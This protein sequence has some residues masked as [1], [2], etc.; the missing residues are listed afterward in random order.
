M[1]TVSFYNRETGEITGTI[2]VS[3]SVDLTTQLQGQDWIEGNWPGNRYQVL[4]AQVCEIPALPADHDLS[5]H[6]SWNHRQQQWQPNL[7]RAVD[8]LRR[9]RSLDL[10]RLDRVNAIWW[11]TLSPDQQAEL[12]AYRQA[13]LDVPQQPGFPEQVEWPQ[14]PAWLG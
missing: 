14:P 8:D 10:D 5:L 6:W 4:D 1:K 9:R 12:V 13:L 2:S 7:Q 11:S 3:N